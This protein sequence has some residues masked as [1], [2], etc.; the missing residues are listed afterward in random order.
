[1][2]P[3]FQTESY[4]PAFNYLFENDFK[5]IFPE[6]FLVTTI[7]LL[8]IYGV[9]L[10]TSKSQSYPLLIGPIVWLGLLTLFFTLVLLIK[11]PLST[12]SIFY[13]TLILDQPTQFFKIIALGGAFFSILISLDY[14]KKEGQNG[15][16]IIILTLLSTSSIL[17]L[18]S[19]ADFISMYLA[20]EFQS[21]CFYVMAGSKRDSEFSTEAGLKYFLLG[22]FSSGLLLFGCSLIYGFTG[23]TLFTELGK[24]FTPGGQEVV[25]GLYSLRGC[26]L[27]MIF[28]LVG[29]LFKLTAVP[30]HMWAPDVYEGAPTSITAFFSITPKISI[31]AV[32]CRVFLEGFYDLMIDWQTILI[33]SSLASMILGSVGA[34]SQNKIKRLLAYSSIGHVGYLLAGL[35]CGTIEGVQ[36]LL[37]YLVVYVL[38]TINI[39]GI[40]LFPL[41]REFI[42]SVQRIKYTTDLGM[43]AKTNPVLSFTL[44]VSLFSIAGIPPLAGFYSKAFLFFAALS[45]N[46]YLLAVIGVLT[47]VISC[48][49]YIRVVKVM[50]FETPKNWLSFSQIPKS[51]SLVV[52][53]S[54]FF[55]LFF[56]LYPNPLYLATHKVALAISL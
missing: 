32:F 14:M 41:R 21:L 53:V 45:S 20:I 28:I 34:L 37:I 22:A 12:G 15:F 56:V 9:V 2:F 54:F 11:N 29:L 27:G 49:Y 46:L 35:C 25:T 8:L 10:S 30:F 16:E 47:S 50:Y 3:S 18:I 5:G 51:S 7:L 43:M 33:F 6:L 31:L 19:S 42:N 26:E 17:F 4:Y 1:M 23:I 36:G 24:L 13:N 38:M 52:G 39:F 55:I 48:F 40:I 44:T